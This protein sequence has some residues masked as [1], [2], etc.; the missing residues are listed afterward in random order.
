MEKPIN[1]NE[2]VQ[3]IKQVGQDKVRAVP[4][5]GQNVHSGMYQI[6]VLEGAGWVPIAEGMA[7]STAN[8]I[9]QKAANRVICG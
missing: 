4:M 6:E 1:I 5:P 8:D 2:A 3:R 9:I 7:Q